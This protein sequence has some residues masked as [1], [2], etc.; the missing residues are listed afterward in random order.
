M[1][2][3]EEHE[4][5]LDALISKVYADYQNGTI[6]DH[7]Q[8]RKLASVAVG[9]GFEAGYELGHKAGYDKGYDKGFADCQDEFGD[10][11]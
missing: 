3:N 11:D 9:A 8:L 4:K 6:L 7:M 1:E 5:Y 2:K 10:E